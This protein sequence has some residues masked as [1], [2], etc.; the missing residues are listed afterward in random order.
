MPVRLAAIVMMGSLTMFTAHA[1]A[2]GRGGPPGSGGAPFSNPAP[3][4]FDNV[5]RYV[6][7]GNG[8]VTDTVTGLIWLRDATCLGTSDF[9]NANGLAAALQ[10]GECGLSD[11]SR[12]GDWRLPTEPEWAAT[13]NRA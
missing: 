3:P 6:D 7:C 10:E 8:T 2:Q 5:N 9:A 1:A 11:G 4:C 13:I 12:A